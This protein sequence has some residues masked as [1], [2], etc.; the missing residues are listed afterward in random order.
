M[1]EIYPTINIWRPPGQV[2]NDIVDKVQW[3]GITFCRCAELYAL[4]RHLHQAHSL[5]K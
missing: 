5:F 3:V 4:L 1:L 2:C